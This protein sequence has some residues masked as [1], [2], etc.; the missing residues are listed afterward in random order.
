[1]GEILAVLPTYTVRDFCDKSFDLSPLP[2]PSCYIC[3]IGGCDVDIWQITVVGDELALTD[4]SKGLVD[5]VATITKD[6]NNFVLRSSLFDLLEAGHDVRSRAFDLVG[7]LN[8]IAKLRTHMRTPITLGN[9]V[10]IKADGS[11]H[12]Y[13]QA[14]AAIMLDGSAAVQMSIGGSESEPSHA[15]LAGRPQ[16]SE[17]LSLAISDPNV[18]DVWY[19][20][21]L[22]GKDRNNLFKILEVIKKDVGGRDKLI[23]KGWQPEPSIS[24][25]ANTTNSKE[26]IGYEAR[27]GVAKHKPPKNPM[28]WDESYAFI[29][30]LMSQWLSWKQSRLRT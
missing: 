5:P 22:P 20:Y 27:H 17:D 8:G 18:K 12:Y 16:A 19:F 14:E 3:S 11:R 28:T 24:C 25:F 30:S 2:C 15:S 13:V 7:I 29:T 4:L 6:N 10:K 1:M 21:G 23:E 26:A 9:A